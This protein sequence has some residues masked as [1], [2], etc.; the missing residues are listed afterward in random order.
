M[1]ELTLQFSGGGP[2]LEFKSG[3]NPEDLEGEGT[4]I[5]VLD[6]ASKLRQQVYDSVKTTT[7]ITR[8]LI[9]PFSTPRGKNWFY[10]KGMEAK[11]IMD[12]QL[13]RNKRLTHMFITAPSTDSP[14]VTPEA[15]EEAKRS[16][17]DRLFRQYYLAEFLDDGSVFVGF[18]DCVLGPE[19]VFD[20]K[21]QYWLDE[22]AENSTVV[23][24]AD[25]AKT[26][27]RTVFWAI[28]V[29]ARVCV[30]FWRFYK[31]PYTEAIRRLVK[32]SRK[33]KDVLIVH[34]DKTGLGTVIDDYLAE[35]EL[36]YEGITFTNATKADMVSKL[37]TGFETKDHFVPNWREAVDELDA[38]EVLT[39]P[40]GNMTYGA[41][42]GKH[43]DIVSAMMLAYLALV[44]YGDRDYTVKSLEPTPEQQKEK[45]KADQGQ[46]V[47][48]ND[49]VEKEPVPRKTAFEQFYDSLRNDDDDDDD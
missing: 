48:N 11:D 15:I 42:E 33:F 2:R 12:W 4:E 1:G 17:P 40:S 28:D 35:T 8:G 18:R 43:D 21:Q 5:N 23:I 34:H 9:A 27:D 44:R 32:F 13:K 37:I 46:K 49:K 22:D 26:Q 36:P 24:G 14:L 31:T 30:G 41:P 6:E 39:T 3:S 45:A 16:L 25:W 29:N 7:T 20:G 38:Y 19:M 47:S 10:T